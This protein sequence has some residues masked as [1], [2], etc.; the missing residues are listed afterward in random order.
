M[1]EVA[2][3]IA[4]T[5]PSSLVFAFWRLTLDALA[6]M[7]NSKGIDYVQIDGRVNGVDRQKHLSRFQDEPQVRVLLMTLETGS[8][9]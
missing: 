1:P 7:L 8:V 6:A 3:K 9:G 5:S 2:Y 4:N